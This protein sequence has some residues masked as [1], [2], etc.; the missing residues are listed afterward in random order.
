MYIVLFANIVVREARHLN[1]VCGDHNSGEFSAWISTLRSLLITMIII[2]NIIHVVE[3]TAFFDQSMQCCKMYTHPLEPKYMD[4]RD[5]ALF[6]YNSCQSG[7]HAYFLL[8]VIFEKIRWVLLSE[9]PFEILKCE[10]LAHK[11]FGCWADVKKNAFIQLEQTK[12]MRILIVLIIKCNR[13]IT[14]LDKL[15]SILA[16]IKD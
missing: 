1:C 15:R 11:G 8:D 4:L 12:N 6:C 10:T 9:S 13:Q 3:C 14:L 16:N 2:I 7:V 5:I